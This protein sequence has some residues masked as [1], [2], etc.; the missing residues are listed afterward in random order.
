MNT[1][2]ADDSKCIDHTD[3]ETLRRLY[4]RE[5]LTTYEIADRSEVSPTQ[6]RYWMDKHD[7]DREDPSVSGR[8]EVDYVGFRTDERGY[9][10]WTY[11]DPETKGTRTFGVHRLV[12]IAEHGIE[13]VAG[14]DIHHENEIPWDNRPSN[15]TP[16]GRGDHLKLHK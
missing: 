1:N 12:A 14:N 7:I 11:Y 4:F 10:V 15:L 2:D 6:I 16:L 9:E 3:A 8:P 5:D 13:A